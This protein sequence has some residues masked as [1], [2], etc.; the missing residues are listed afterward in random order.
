[1]SSRLSSKHF[2]NIR[3]RK[4]ALARR[5]RRLWALEGLEGRALLSGDPTV[6]TVTNTSD[7][8][9]DTGSLR[10]AV[11]QANANSNSAGSMIEF[12]FTTPQTIT[13]SSTLVLN[14]SAGPEVVQG[15]GANLLTIS[16][17]GPF[18]SAFPAVNYGVCQVDN[19]AAATLSGLTISHGDAI[20]GGGIANWGALTVRDCSVTGNSA[21]TSST[22]ASSTSAG[23]GIWNSGTLSVEGSTIANNV[24]VRGGGIY[25]SSGVVTITNSTVANN[26]SGL[27]R[28]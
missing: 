1:M 19:G 11:T 12:A 13:L 17:T 21:G 24:A 20:K 28:F 7:S 25:V 5:R 2:S 8:A 9:S 4:H 16:G 18:G 15:P 6:Y 27:N 3:A 22:N 10:Y 14:E 26:I 23:G